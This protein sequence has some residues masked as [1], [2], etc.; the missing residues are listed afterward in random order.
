MALRIDLLVA[1]IGSTTTTVTAFDRL[2][3]DEPRFL[4]QAFHP[5]TVEEG[6]VLTGL[7]GATRALARSLDV[8]GIEPREVVATSSAAGGLK[9]TVHGLVYEMTVKAA[10]EAALGAGAIVKLVTAGEISPDDLQRVRDLRPNIILL[11]GGVD[12]GERKTA[13]FNARLLARPARD[14]PIIYGGNIACQDEIERILGPKT[15]IVENVYPRIDRLNVEPTRRVIQE[16]F[17]EH[18]VHA[19]GMAH[20]REMVTGTIIPTPAAVMEAARLMRELIGDLLVIDVGGATTDVHSVTEGSEE[21]AAM[22]IAPEPLAKRTVEGDLGVFVN[23]RHLAAQLGMERLDRE[24]G[25]AVA[26]IL[27]RLEQIP[28]DD[29]ARSMVVRLTRGAAETAIDRHVG[30][31]SY[32]YGPSGRISVA[33]GKD[34]TAVRWLI[35]TGG[36][37]T[38][39]LGGHEILEGIMGRKRPAALMP[40]EAA[41]LIDRDYIMAAVGAIS[42]S[43]PHAAGRLLARSLGVTLPVGP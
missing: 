14:I 39:L 1:E 26:P 7:T 32:L 18:I 22:L 35:G 41:V 23:A 17:E 2:S 40:K 30:R 37:L 42:R 4:G 11:A 25:F 38:Q 19:P 5:T 13:L 43:H 3:E 15:Y 34:L 29:R 12:Y 36:P 24:L 20:V 27:D 10:N 9:M 16:V 33:E 21:I 8:S 28:R 6:D 31:T